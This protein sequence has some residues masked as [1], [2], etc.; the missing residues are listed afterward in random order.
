LRGFQATLHD[1]EINLSGEGALD[2]FRKE[3]FLH[4]INFWRVVV[5]VVMAII[6]VM[7]LLADNFLSLTAKGI[8]SQSA[9]NQQGDQLSQI[10]ALEASSSVFNQ[11]V[12]LIQSVE[13]QQSP[14]TPV[15]TEINNLAASNQITIDH[16]SLTASTDPILVSGLSSNEDQIIAFKAAIQSDSKF[17]P[18]N[19]SF[20]NIQLNNGV[21]SFSM[22]FPLSPSA[23]QR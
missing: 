18:V 22:T 10:A 9:F 8:A 7:F 15:I 19:L 3:Q 20:S 1:K 4:F 16:I 2:T 12:A 21:Y 11:S 17:G 13:S 5:P 14:I 23:F 6:V